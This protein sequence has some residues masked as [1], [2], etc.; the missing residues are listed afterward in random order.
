M[1]PSVLL[2]VD[3]TATSPSH[4]A[5]EVLVSCLRLA[6][7]G[8]WLRPDPHAET[9]RVLSLGRVLRPHTSFFMLGERLDLATAL[10]V[11]AVHL[12]SW[13]FSLANA[14]AFLRSA[15]G[16][17]QRVCTAVH[18]RDQ[19]LLATNARHPAD[20]VLVSP[21]YDVPNK[22]T[23]LGLAGLVS[24][25]SSAPAVSAFALGGLTEIHHAM[26]VGLHGA[27]G[28]VVRRGWQRGSLHIASMRDAF[29][30]GQRKST[31][32]LGD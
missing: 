31:R 25:V 26:D 21:V 9:S 15:R 12:P 13:S 29:E 22:G 5:L 3:T 28:L 18:S 4:D 10:Q 19:M 2:C 30:M 16:A 24:V 23:P 1:L 7:V 20:F 14:R 8:L 6:R 32:A 17:T 11:N 27:C